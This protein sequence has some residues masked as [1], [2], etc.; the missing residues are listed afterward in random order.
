MPLKFTA[1][2]GR[3]LA[4]ID[5]YI[6]LYGVAPAEAD[7]QAYFRTTAPSVH[8]MVV[9]LDRNCLITRTPGLARSIKVLVPR[10]FIPDLKTGEVV[11][12]ASRHPHVAAW[13]KVRGRTVE[14]GHDSKTNTWARAISENG[15][16][17]GGGNALNTIDELLAALN[18]EIG[19][20]PPTQ[21]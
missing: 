8:Q 12:M 6:R 1:K 5:H 20:L 3:Y 18:T 7:M 13:L 10:E 16:V 4:F 2:Q 11:T 17:W 9:T 15:L 21:R 19:A 14:L